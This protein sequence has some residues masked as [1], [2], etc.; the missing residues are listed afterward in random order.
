MTL[1][2]TFRRQAFWTWDSLRQARSVSCQLGEESL[3]DFNLLR[4][5]KRHP[6]EVFTHTFTKPQEAKT[7]ADWEW[8]FTGPSGGWVGFRVQAKVLDL[9]TETFKHLHYKL[10]PGPFQSDV[11]IDHARALQPARIPVYCLYVHAR[12]W[13][14]IRRV[15]AC[16]PYPTTARSFGCALIDAH[17]IQRMRCSTPMDTRLTKIL[18]F[19]TPWHCLVC[20]E[21]STAGDLPV[22][23]RA[24]WLGRQSMHEARVGEVPELTDRP[25]SYVT[26]LMQGNLTDPPADDPALRTVTVFKELE[27]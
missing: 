25:P 4:I 16:R 11:L 15:F 21:G 9:R 20:C 14:S 17:E 10:K 3:T 13:R 18:R 2:D 24:F 26:A 7:G 22:R 19:A 8:W 23:A 5:R 12:D 6:R 1:C 27:S